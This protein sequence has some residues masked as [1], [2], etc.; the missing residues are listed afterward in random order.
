M[1]AI[2]HDYKKAVYGFLC[3]LLF[4]W[5]LAVIRQFLPLPAFFV[6]TTATILGLY[7]TYLI[8]ILGRYFWR[9]RDLAELKDL[10]VG[11]LGN[12]W[13]Y[14]RGKIIAVALLTFCLF[15]G[16]IF[17]AASLKGLAD[18]SLHF[19]S[20]Q[21]GQAVPDVNKYETDKKAAIAAAK[22]NGKTV[23]TRDLDFGGKAMALA[24]NIS[25]AFA[26][27]ISSS[28]MQIFDISFVKDTTPEA[29]MHNG[30]NPS[31]D[32]AQRPSPQQGHS[33]QP[34]NSIPFN[35][36]LPPFSASDDAGV[37]PTGGRGGKPDPAKIRPEPKHLP[38]PKI[39]GKDVIEHKPSFINDNRP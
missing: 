2:P 33:P 23:E 21:F 18:G 1:R 38:P 34:E 37:D 11:G 15:L 28:A 10:L 24:V 5:G 30:I 17:R 7:G 16:G 36:W 19:L 13:K 4:I 14:H 3:L 12:V 35:S 8:D 39:R 26:N 22:K 20:A 27:A 29:W 32:A 6:I 31:P 25:S 9:R